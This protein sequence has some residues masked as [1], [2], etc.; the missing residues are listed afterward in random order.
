V[1]GLSLKLEELEEY[2]FTP[3]SQPDLASVSPDGT[4]N[5]GTFGPSVFHLP[6][7][8]GKLDWSCCLERSFRETRA[9]LWRNLVISVHGHR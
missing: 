8:S 9:E 7:T 5:D 3:G 2:P 4:R 6:V 1:K